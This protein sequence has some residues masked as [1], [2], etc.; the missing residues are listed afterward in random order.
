[1]T[2]PG[3][4]RRGRGCGGRRGGDRRDQGAAAHGTAHR[5][6]VHGDV[7]RTRRL[8]ADRA[9]RGVARGAA[10]DGRR[11]GSTG[12][13]HI[14]VDAPATRGREVDGDVPRRG[15]GV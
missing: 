3:A 9:P 1:E 5:P 8:V 12:G 11:P 15:E 4:V 10:R 13:G 6:V 14:H 2:H 7:V